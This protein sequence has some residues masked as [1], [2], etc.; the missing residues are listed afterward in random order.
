MK[1]KYFEFALSG[2]SSTVYWPV[3][4]YISTQEYTVAIRQV[5][6]TGNLT[7]A[8]SAAVTIDRVL[9]RGVTSAVFVQVSAGAGFQATFEDPATCFRFVV[10]ASGAVGVQIAALQ[11][12]P[13]RVF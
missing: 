1:T 5:S 3:D 2:G 4:S 8:T 11:T 10:A 13:D 7:A 12:G 6:G 9:A